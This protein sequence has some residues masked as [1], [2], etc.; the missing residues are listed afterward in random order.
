MIIWYTSICSVPLHNTFIVQATSVNVIN[1]LQLFS[2]SLM[3]QKKQAGAYVSS[4]ISDCSNIRRQRLA[5][6]PKDRALEPTNTLAYF[7]SLREKKV[8]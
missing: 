6:Q 2:S 7:A 5:N 1:T 3:H 4:K 8:W